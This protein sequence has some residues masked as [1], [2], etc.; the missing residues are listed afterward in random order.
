MKKAMGWPVKEVKPKTVTYGDYRCIDGEVTADKVAELTN[1]LIT[2]AKRT[3]RVVGHDV[4]V[5]GV[6]LIFDLKAVDDAPE[7]PPLTM[8]WKC[9]VDV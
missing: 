1:E 5:V 8:G 2:S 4:N 9:E 3:M 6:R 7:V